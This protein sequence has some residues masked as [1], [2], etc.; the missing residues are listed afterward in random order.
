MTISKVSNGSTGAFTFTNTNLASG[1]TNLTTA[2]AGVAVSSAAI[3]V[4]SLSSN[5]QIQEPVPSGWQLSSASCTD[6]NGTLTTNGTGTFGSLAGNTLTIPTANLVYGAD[7]RCTFTNTKRPTLRIT[8]ISQGGTGTFTFTG[9]NGWASQGITTAAAGGSG[10]AGALQ[11]LTTSSTATTIT[12]ALAAGYTMTG[13]SCTGMGATGTV[14][15][16]LSAGTFTLNAAA[17]AAGSNISCT[18]TNTKTPTVKI[19]KTTTG[20]FGGRLVLTKQILLARL[21]TLRQPLQARRHELHQL[22]LM[23]ARLVQP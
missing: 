4:A 22:L 6:A 3:N 7:I 20:G 17:T 1:T 18:V 9:D 15:P 11:T 12:E 21:A 16:N 5:V 23:S 13:V 19:Q 2:T 8:K 10:T 14:T